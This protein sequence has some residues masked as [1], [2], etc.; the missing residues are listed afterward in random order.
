MRTKI[1]LLTVLMALMAVG[2]AQAEV[3]LFDGF[4][5]PCVPAIFEYG[6][7]SPDF[8]EYVWVFLGFNRDGDWPP[9]EIGPEEWDG[10][11]H[12]YAGIVNVGGGTNLVNY[13]GNQYLYVFNNLPSGT[14]DGC[15]VTSTAARLDAKIAA[16]TTYSLTLKTASDFVPW[17]PQSYHVQLIAIDD[18]NSVD[19]VLAEVSGPV[20]D[21]D[22]ATQ[23]NQ[24]SLACRVDAGSPHIGERIAVRLRKG[25]GI[26]YHNVFYDDVRLTADSMNV[27]PYDG[28]QV[29]YG[30]V[31]LSWNNMEP[32]S[33]G[34]GSVYV[35]VKFALDPNFVDLVPGYATVDLL[36]AAQDV[37]TVPIT[38]V[39]GTTYYWQIISYL[40]GDPGTVTYGTDPNAIVSSVYKFTAL[41]DMPIT[42]VDIQYDGVDVNPGSVVTWSDEPTPLSVDVDDDGVS[43]LSHVWSCNLTDVVITGGTTATPTITLTKAPGVGV[44]PLANADFE[45][46]FEQGGWWWYLNDGVRDYLGGER[47]FGWTS[48]NWGYSYNPHCGVYNPNTS[49]YAGSL[50]PDGRNVAFIESRFMI[51]DN[52]P[53]G[54][55]W[56]NTDTAIV[57]GVTYTLN[58]KVGQPLYNTNDEFPGYRVRLVAHGGSLLAEDNN[59]LTMVPG[60]FQQSTVTFA[61]PEGHADIGRNLRI[62]LTTNATVVAREGE[63]TENDDYEVHFDSVSL[64]SDNSTTVLVTVAVTDAVTPP[65]T[66]TISV[67]V[68]DNECAAKLAIVTGAEDHAGDINSDCVTDIHDFGI[69]AGTWLNDT[70][71]TEP[72]DKGTLGAVRSD[73]NI[74]EVSAGADMVTLSGLAVQLDPDVTNNTSDPVQILTY[75]WTA[76]PDT[77]VVISDPNALAPT[78]TVTRES[79]YSLFL[80]NGSFE[81]PELANDAYVTT[82]GVANWSTEWSEAG[83][84]TWAP[85]G[86]AN[87]GAWDPNDGEYY[88]VIPDGENVG[89]VE[90]DPGYDHCLYQELSI[91]LQPSTAYVLSAKVGNPTDV[92]TNDYRIEIVND[93]LGVLASSGGAS[94]NGTTDPEWL[95]ASVSF[96]SDAVVTAGKTLAIRLVAEAEALEGEIREVNFDAVELTVDGEV[97]ASTYGTDPATVTMN[98]AVSYDG[99]AYASRDDQMTIDVY[100]DACLAKKATPETL[101]QADLNGD[102]ITSLADLAILI[103]SWTVDVGALT[104]PVINP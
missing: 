81:D 67:T 10:S 48:P 53:S 77:G 96:T 44:V 21:N 6:N 97:G 62:E 19:T 30:T 4:E 38:A 80:L 82:G 1:I 24:I 15:V 50:A 90:T 78:V 57:A 32:N 28:E 40:H 17:Y 60:E 98:L 56:Q 13:S 84:D 95:D 61:C 51:G 83:L 91:T 52:T 64:T 86:S 8:S 41:S 16:D 33:L 29:G 85:D 68:Y 18:V 99:Y 79:V 75:R 42:D 63:A 102:C 36:T 72:S 27:S 70:E 22:F 34:D 3:L 101:D 73:P 25:N 104:V 59:G 35:D 103:D 76:N 20:A 12:K 87:G 92:P 55:L 49:A 93:D 54:G 89:Y 100:V 31:D 74:A 11:N 9:I 58:V 47:Q 71:L 46:Y 45:D 5:D 88:V 14:Y 7:T 43:G 66:D 94:P 23:G 2:T 37:N 69:V 39:G 65:V 26:Y